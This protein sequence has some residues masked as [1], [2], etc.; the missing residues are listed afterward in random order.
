[1]HSS[2]CY[3]NHT[4]NRQHH[5]TLCNIA[6]LCLG[7]SSDAL[8]LRD[9]GIL[10]IDDAT[11]EEDEGL[12][13]PLTARSKESHRRWADIPLLSVTGSLVSAETPSS[14]PATTGFDDVNL[15][16]REEVVEV[17]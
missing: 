16:L 5:A 1:M 17:L 12:D 4:C 15:D 3:G 10:T 7:L 6:G 9:N 2:C 14:Q 13:G 8:S 11:M